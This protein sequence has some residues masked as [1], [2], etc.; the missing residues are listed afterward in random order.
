MIPHEKQNS[1]ESKI[2]FESH[3]IKIKTE[4]KEEIK[5]ENEIGGIHV[6]TLD[7][8]GKI[9]ELGNAER[10]HQKNQN[11]ANSESK[12]S[13]NPVENIET[14]HF[15]EITTKNSDSREKNNSVLYF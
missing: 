1:D 12:E 2:V 10:D 3:N 13:Q 4:I 14:T 15:D 9:C 5:M 11:F 7:G 6:Y 8:E